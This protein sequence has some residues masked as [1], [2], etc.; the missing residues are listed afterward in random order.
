VQTPTPSPAIPFTL[1][2]KY[3]KGSGNI[4]KEEKRKMRYA[5]MGEM[6]LLIEGDHIYSLLAAPF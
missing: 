5:I 6:H 4:V 1:L 2:K 3:C